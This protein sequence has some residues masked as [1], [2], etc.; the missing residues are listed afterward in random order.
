MVKFVSVCVERDKK[1]LK[2]WIF[3][4]TSLHIWL[5]FRRSTGVSRRSKMDARFSMLDSGYL[6]LEKSF[7]AENAKARMILAVFLCNRMFNPMLLQNEQRTM[8]LFVLHD[9]K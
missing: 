9:D 6:I 2:K 5:I 3:A 7:T 8:N 1:N 4:L